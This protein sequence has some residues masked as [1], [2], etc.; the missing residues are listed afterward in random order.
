MTAIPASR[1]AALVPA[2]LLR[3]AL[4]ADAAASGAM[5]LLLLAG[6]AA[7]SGPFGLPAALLQG[8]G[9]ALLPWA[10]LVFWMSRRPSLPG[11]GVWAIIGLNLAW[12]VESVLLLLSGWVSPTGLGIA[13]VLAQ[14]A[15]VD[16]FATAQWLGLRRSV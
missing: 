1:P 5:G 16:A 8:A 14:A 10:A 13:F 3:L 12:V 15:A 2:K 9:A 4:L 7:L 11:W 6:G